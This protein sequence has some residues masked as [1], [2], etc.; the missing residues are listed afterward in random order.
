MIR[1]IWFLYD[2]DRCLFALVFCL[3]SIPR[4]H[5]STT[6]MRKSTP[7]TIATFTVLHTSIHIHRTTDR[8]Q[9]TNEPT[10]QPIILSCVIHDHRCAATHCS[11]T[12]RPFLSSFLFPTRH[13]AQPNTTLYT[14]NSIPTHHATRYRT[15]HT[16]PSSSTLPIFFPSFLPPI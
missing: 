3:S 14:I 12:K 5:S 8:P 6:R 16:Y 4:Y 9:S 10:N 13:S 2:S 15:H 1:M 11:I 7:T